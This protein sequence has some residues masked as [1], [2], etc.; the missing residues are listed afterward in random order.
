MKG[1]KI[2]MIPGDVMDLLAVQWWQRRSTCMPGNTVV[3]R[4]VDVA[5]CWQLLIC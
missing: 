2:A 4:S 1:L 5:R 3:R